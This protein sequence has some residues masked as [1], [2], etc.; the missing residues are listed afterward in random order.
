MKKLVTAIVLA[1]L[2][3]SARVEARP[4]GREKRAIGIVF[5]VMGIVHLSFVGAFAYS[6]A[7]SCNCHEPPND[8]LGLIGMG[9]SAP[10][11]ATFLGVGIPYWVIGQRE[12]SSSKRVSIAPNG[13]TIAF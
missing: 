7:T 8:L 3:S 11:A 12:V 10:L 5:T 13:V 2:V 6:Y 1:L 4:S 9:V